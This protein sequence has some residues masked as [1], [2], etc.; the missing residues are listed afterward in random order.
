ME[1]ETDMLGC[2]LE[3]IKKLLGGAETGRNLGGYLK[4]Y[5]LKKLNI[6]N[7]SRDESCIQLFVG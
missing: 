6:I 4:V 3:R 1:I 7:A 2:A 5:R